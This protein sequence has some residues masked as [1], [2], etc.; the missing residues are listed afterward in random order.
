MS[1]SRTVL[2]GALL[3]L[4]LC[5]CNPR[6]GDPAP[7]PPVTARQV[8]SG[9]PPPPPPP[10][11]DRGDVLHY[12]A[13]KATPRRELSA[14]EQCVIEA[15]AKACTPAKDCLVSCIASPHGIEEGGGCSHV[16]FFGLHPPASNPGIPEACES[17]PAGAITSPATSG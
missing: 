5:A 1:G 4:A 11:P 9:Q 2:P 12:H 14:R 3:L 6:D 15:Y 16:C 8:D 7:R 17:L 13:C 10:P